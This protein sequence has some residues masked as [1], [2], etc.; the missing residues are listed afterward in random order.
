MIKIER[1]GPGVVLVYWTDIKDVRD[2]QVAL[3]GIAKPHESNYQDA[4]GRV[5]EL[6]ERASNEALVDAVIASLRKPVSS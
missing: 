6:R 3:L 4:A 2:A 1:E 5:G